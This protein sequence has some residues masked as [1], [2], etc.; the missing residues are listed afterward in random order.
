M[1]PQSVAQLVDWTGGTLLQGD[2]TAMITAVSTDSRSL[3]PGSLFVALVGEKFDA[4]HFLDQA[5]AAG[6]GAFLVCRELPAYP[7][8]AVI[9]VED[10]L[11]GQQRLAAA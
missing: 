3:P 8:G 2:P 4:H 10:T 1:K 9:L 6:A 5:A 7:T 11:L